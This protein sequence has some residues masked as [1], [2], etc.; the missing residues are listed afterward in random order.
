MNHSRCYSEDATIS[1]VLPPTTLHFERVWLRRPRFSTL[2]ASC[3]LKPGAAAAVNVR[4]RVQRR[5]ESEPPLKPNHCGGLEVSGRICPC[6]ETDREAFSLP[7]LVSI[8]VLPLPEQRWLPLLQDVLETLQYAL[9]PRP[10]VPHTHR[11]RSHDTKPRNSSAARFP[12]RL[13]LQRSLTRAVIF[14]SLFTSG[15]VARRPRVRRKISPPQMSLL[16]SLFC[17]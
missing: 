15:L 7:H 12:P 9:P 11:G 1:T 17:W 2:L 3:I 14:P 16:A 6:P 13:I 10:K 8:S 4:W 5:N